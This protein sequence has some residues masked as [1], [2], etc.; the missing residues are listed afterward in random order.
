MYIWQLFELF[1]GM[2]ITHLIDYEFSITI[3]F[4]RTCHV[5]FYVVLNDLD[6]D[7]EHNHDMEDQWTKVTLDHLTEK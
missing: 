2:N 5:D 7:D 1:L 3:K 4:R 6:L